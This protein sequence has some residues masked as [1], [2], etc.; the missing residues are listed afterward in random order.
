MRERLVWIVLLVLGTGGGFYAG[1][2]NGIQVGLAQAQQTA[3]R[4]LADRGAGGNGGGVRG[5][6]GRRGN[7]QGQNLTGTVEAIDGQTITVKNRNNVTAKVQL[8]ADATIRKQVSGQVSD[9]HTGDQIVV[10]GTKSGNVFQ[11]ASVQ[12]GGGFGGRGASQNQSAGQ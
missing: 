5:N 3:S 2:Q 1:R 8:N 9:I 12:I 10:N 7:T 6:G 4:F 11:A